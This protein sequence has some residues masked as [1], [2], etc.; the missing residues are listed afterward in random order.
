MYDKRRRSSSSRSRGRSR[1]RRRSFRSENSN[2]GNAVNS[3]G[4]LYIS[5]L[6][7]EAREK[8]LRVIFEKYPSLE[9]CTVIID[10][11]T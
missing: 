4:M 10:P 9:S 3:G 11:I 8:D 5:R 7:Y 6:S 2:D 1:T